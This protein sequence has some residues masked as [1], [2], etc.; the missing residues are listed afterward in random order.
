[1]T[2][3]NHITTYAFAI[4]EFVAPTYRPERYYMRGPGPA[5]ARRGHSLEARVSF[6]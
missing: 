6:H 5:C 3:W 1:M 4:R 2:L